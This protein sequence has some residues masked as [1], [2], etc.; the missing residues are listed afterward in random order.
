[1]I[2]NDKDYR[3]IEVGDL[4]D[5]NGDKDYRIIVTVYG[6]NDSYALMNPSSSVVTTRAYKT[7]DELVETQKLTLV[8]KADEIELKR[9]EAK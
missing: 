8:A 4:V 7:L 5:F 6:Y 3:K 1:M 9:K 2:F